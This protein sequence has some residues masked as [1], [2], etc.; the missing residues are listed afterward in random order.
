MVG[1][2][3]GNKIRSIDLSGIIF[4][5]DRATGIYLLTVP[6]AIV[7]K[8][9]ATARQYITDGTTEVH[10]Y[11]NHFPFSIDVEIVILVPSIIMRFIG[12]RRFCGIIC[13]SLTRA[14]RTGKCCPPPV[15]P[16]SHRPRNGSEG[17][18]PTLLEQ[19]PLQYIYSSFSHDR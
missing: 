5:S 15:A 18:L 19:Y 3:M 8:K 11:P 13:T 14:L 1:H 4:S 7:E 16:D 12:L 17:M 6:M 2:R 9:K 10:R